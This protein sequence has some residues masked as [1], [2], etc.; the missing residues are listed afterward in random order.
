MYEYKTEFN[1]QRQILLL[2]EDV[3]WL[4]ER[5]NVR[6]PEDVVDICRTLLRLDKQTEEQVYCFCLDTKS[7]IGFFQVSTGNA[8]Q[9]FVDPRVVFCKALLVGATRIVLVHNHPSGD[10]NPSE[11]DKLMTTRMAEGG[12]LL[13]V[14]LED[15]VI[16]GE[17][18]FFSFLENAPTFLNGEV[19]V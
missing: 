9:A 19:A 7:V 5:Q 15:S 4:S 16:I 11:E 6:N 8:T 13:N 12:K 14:I 18:S 10:S 2:R 3:R 1:D 17:H